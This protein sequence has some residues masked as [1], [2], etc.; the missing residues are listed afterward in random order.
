MS[1]KRKR[2]M[3]GVRSTKKTKGVPSQPSISSAVSLPSRKRTRGLVSDGKFT[4]P[5][6]KTISYS[7]TPNRKSFVEVLKVNWFWLNYIVKIVVVIAVVIFFANRNTHTRVVV[8][9]HIE[10]LELQDE[11]SAYANPKEGELGFDIIA[12]TDEVSIPIEPAGTRPLAKKAKGKITIYNNYS[13][14]PQRLLPET[15]FESA[16]GKIFRIGDKEVIIPGMEGNNPGTIVVEVTADQAGPEYNLGITDFSIPGFKEIGLDEKYQEIY[17]VSTEKFSGGIVT[18]EAYID[19]A[20]KE[21]AEQVLRDQ[22]KERLT[23][24][25]LKENTD[26]VLIV[27]KS[28]Q[29]RFKSSEFTRGETEQQGALRKQGIIVALALSKDVLDT[30]SIANY[31]S[32]DENETVQVIDNEFVHVT[33]VDQTIDYQDLSQVHLNVEG[34]ILVE[35]EIAK[36]ILRKQLAGLAKEKLTSFL[37]EINSID[38]AEIDIFPPWKKAV[39][40]TLN[41][42]EIQVD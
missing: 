16:S 24:R 4:Q 23:L 30:Y 10:Y 36:E 38:T 17:G 37:Q 8:T 25:L 6:K 5:S 27:E 39:S 26:K 29:I 32:L 3:D 31:L 42:I 40:R 21:Q 18:T 9:P 33:L 28:A 35:W 34:K 13:S 41:N 7:S 15:R 11:V 1:E 20:Q 22:L 14:E 19:E 12:I 2:S